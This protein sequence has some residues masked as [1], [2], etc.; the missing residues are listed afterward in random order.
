MSEKA[1][2]INQ[3]ERNKDEPLLQNIRLLRDTLRDQEGVEA[4]DLVERIRKLAIR[5]QR[6]DD[7][8]ARQELTALLSPLAS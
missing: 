2:P 8:P 6:D 7:L 3:E 1:T 4:F 5:F